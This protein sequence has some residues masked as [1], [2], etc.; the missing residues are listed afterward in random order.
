MSICRRLKIGAATLASVLATCATAALPTASADTCTVTAALLTGQTETFVVDEAPGTPP[1]QMVPAGVQYRSVT[2]SCRSTTTI[3][4]TTSSTGPHLVD[5]SGHLSFGPGTDSLGALIVYGPG[6]GRVGRFVDDTTPDE[7]KV[8]QEE[9]AAGVPLIIAA[10]AP[11][12]PHVR[13]AHALNAQEWY[14]YHSGY[15]PRS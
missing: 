12:T 15:A 3:P 1:S 10:I 4:T 14:P 9:Y 6:G 5:L 2:A 8:V 7:A 11:G 13:F